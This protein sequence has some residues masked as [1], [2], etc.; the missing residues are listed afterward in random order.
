MS[1]AVTWWIYMIV[2]L[3]EASQTEK[4]EYHMILLIFRIKKKKKSSCSVTQLSPILCDSMDCSTPGFPVLHHLLEPAQ[5]HVR[6]VG[7][8]IQPARPLSS[9]FPPVFCLSQYQ[10]LFQWVSFL[11]QMAKIL[12]LQL[13]HQSFQWIFRVKFPWGLTS[14]ISLLS[15]GLLQHHSLKAQFFGAQPSLWSK[16]HI[17][18]WLLKKT[19]I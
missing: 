13:Q 3:S 14:L 19:V 6:W 4:N 10:G 11:H 9:P 2:I 18:T 1:F 16:L 17:H 12:E 5:T 15:K 7:D 8:A